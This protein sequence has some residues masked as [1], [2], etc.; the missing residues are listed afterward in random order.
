MSVSVLLQTSLDSVQISNRPLPHQTSAIL[1]TQSLENVV[2]SK[3]AS[4]C[5][6]LLILT[7]ETAREWQKICLSDCVRNVRTSCKSTRSKPSRVL[8]RFFNMTADYPLHQC[9]VFTYTCHSR[10]DTMRDFSLK[11][12]SDEGS[13]PFVCP[14]CRSVQVISKRDLICTREQL[15]RLLN[16]RIGLLDKVLPQHPRPIQFGEAGEDHC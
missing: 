6:V 15:C 16:I 4:S 7:L 14:A 10:E 9:R 1:Q 5:G 2:S 13:W 8:K 12:A 3:N 11:M